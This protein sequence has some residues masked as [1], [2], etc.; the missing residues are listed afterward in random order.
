MTIYVFDDFDVLQIFKLQQ[1][2]QSFQAGK[3]KA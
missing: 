1:R 3:A 2:I